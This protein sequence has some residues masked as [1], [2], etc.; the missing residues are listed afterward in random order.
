MQK[1]IS[2]LNRL[3]LLARQQVH[4]P[5]DDGVIQP[6]PADLTPAMLAAHLR[7]DETAA[8]GLLSPDGLTRTMVVGFHGATAGKGEQH[9]SKLCE[10]ANA[11]QAQLDLPAPA[12]SVS[13]TG[14]GLWLSLEA[15]VPVARALEF[16]QLLRDEFFADT[17]D[18][19]IDFL[20][21]SADAGDANS[22]TVALPPC[23]HR[24]SGKWAAF[25]NPGMGASFIEDAGLEMAPPPEAQAAFLASVQSMNEA[26]FRQALD[27]LRQTHAAAAIATTLLP[28]PSATAEGLLL[29]DAT[30]EDIVKFLHEKNIEPT[31]RHLIK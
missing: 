17:P 9:W 6:Q 16:L 27:Q 12:V 23:L 13:G 20:P 18:D 10:L 4:R 24:A 25:I 31:F 15:P 3:Y 1:L 8:I 11:L 30:L 22:T 19:A 21:G 26:Q 2:E 5:C 7:G 29:K 28:K 14:Y